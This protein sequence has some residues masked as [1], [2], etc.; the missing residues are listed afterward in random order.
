M[1]IT[2]EIIQQEEIKLKTTRITNL[3]QMILDQK[4]KQLMDSYLFEIKQDN[5]KTYLL[6][7]D[8]N[9]ENSESN[10][11]DTAVDDVSP[12]EHTLPINENDNDQEDVSE[13]S[14]EDYE[15]DNNAY[16]FVDDYLYI[17]KIDE[18]MELSEEDNCID[19]STDDQAQ[20]KVKDNLGSVEI[21]LV[22][23]ANGVFHII[24]ESKTKYNEKL[25][26]LIELLAFKKCLPL[27]VINENNLEIKEVEQNEIDSSINHLEFLKPDKIKL[28]LEDI[29]T[30]RE[31]FNIKSV[32]SVVTLDTD[33]CFSISI[34][35][36]KIYSTKRYSEIKGKD[37][38]EIIDRFIF[39][40]EDDFYNEFSLDLPTQH[41]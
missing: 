11:K 29:Y 41:S 16:S 23:A 15:S 40:F 34:L 27:A 37:Y 38:V 7:V 1:I 39:S 35:N 13:E 3:L 19:Q 26:E 12:S 24:K 2:R 5:N 31:F 20:E 4:E 8:F 21:S 10:P 30:F 14:N 17:P 22:I 18:D 32:S 6:K 36:T 28:D 33:L 9:V 25:Q